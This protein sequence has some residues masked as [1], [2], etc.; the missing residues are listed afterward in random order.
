MEVSV[1]SIYP[2]GFVY[3]SG[4]I[5]PFKLESTRQVHLPIGLESNHQ[6]YLPFKFR[7]PFEMEI[8]LESIYLSGWKVSVGLLNTN[9]GLQ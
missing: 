5:L 6:V 1:G 2:L 7:L 3:P 4:S 8:P 9:V